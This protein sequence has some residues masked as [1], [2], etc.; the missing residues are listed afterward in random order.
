MFWAPRLSAIMTDVLVLTMI[1]STLLSLRPSLLLC[2]TAVDRALSVLGISR[3]LTP[4]FFKL[5]LRMIPVF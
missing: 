2:E 4:D 5:P 1:N 3:R